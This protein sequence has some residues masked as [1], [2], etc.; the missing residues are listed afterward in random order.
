MKLFDTEPSESASRGY[1]LLGAQ[2]ASLFFTGCV[3]WTAV[4]APSLYRHSLPILIGRA[5]G[6]A[7]LAWFWSA[8]ML[9]G[10]YYFFAEPV[11]NPVRR[12]L[13]T[14]TAAVWF[15]PATILLVENSPA[16]MFAALILVVNATRAL[17]SEWRLVQAEPDP[18]LPVCRADGLFEAYALSSPALLGQL[19]P[20]LTLALCIQAGAVA[21]AMQFPLPAAACFALAAA[22]LTA[23]GMAA[24]LLPPERPRDLPR[25]ILGVILTVML[26]AFLTVGGSPGVLMR[27]S[28]GAEVWG[29]R[30]PPGLLETLRALLQ[31]RLPGGAP[32]ALPP[33][34]GPPGAF[35]PGYE[36]ASAPGRVGGNDFPGVI[37]WPEVK[38][39]TTLVAP[40]PAG[41]GF[42]A[43]AAHPLGILFSGEYW[44]FRRPSRRPPYGSFFRRGSPASLGFLTTDHAPLQMEAHHKL[45]QPID[46]RCCGRIQIAIWNADRYPGTVSLELIL[47]D[48]GQPA[49]PL[50]SLGEAPVKSSPGNLPVRETL[51][52]SI[53]AVRV[54]RRFNEFQV[55]F[56]RDRRR[57]DKSARI[58]IDRFVLLPAGSV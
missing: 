43:Q 26:A 53:P 22:F 17:Y 54:L 56:H 11:S 25:S 19:A 50:Q 34:S 21:A 24:G 35:I 31:Q 12:T 58:E 30:R 18:P 40:V 4:V 28:G 52:F 27:G 32:R 38:P 42:S 44:M 29:S 8:A 23:L 57:M 55:V 9:V 45:D 33:L 39:V 41:A 14:A 47:I 15:A 51:E 2:V 48:T 16:A 49:R 5:V 6:F 3:V 1:L 36:P 10:L 20:G 7:L 46:L 37:L 13:R